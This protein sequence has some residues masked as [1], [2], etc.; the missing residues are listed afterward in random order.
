VHLRMDPVVII[1]VVEIQAQALGMLESQ[2]VEEVVI[3][4]EVVVVEEEE[5]QTETF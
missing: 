4:V 2:V 1:M 5:E 3:A